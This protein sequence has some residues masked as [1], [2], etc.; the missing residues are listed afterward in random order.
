MFQIFV[1]FSEYL[2]FI[3][4]KE[5]NYLCSII[6][7]SSS[8]KL[9]H[10]V[11]LPFLILSKYMLPLIS[12]SSIGLAMFLA[13]WFFEI[14]GLI[15]VNLCQ[16]LLIF[17]STNPQYEDRLFIE[18]QVQFMIIQSSNLGRTCCVQKLFLKFRTISVYNI[19]INKY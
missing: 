9:I 2:N 14:L 8:S 18:L 4:V 3:F 6:S 15:Q 13:I 5:N 1:V 16:K 19:K 17:A 12:T 7:H 11:C 10:L